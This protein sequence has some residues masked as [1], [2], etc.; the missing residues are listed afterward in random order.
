MICPVCH[1]DNTKA[2]ATCRACGEASWA[3]PVATPPADPPPKPK[4]GA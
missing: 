1:T 4:K 3:V 2:E